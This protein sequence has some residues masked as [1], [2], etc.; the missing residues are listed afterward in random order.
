MSV[1]RLATRSPWWTCAREPAHSPGSRQVHFVP[2]AS[3][4]FVAI[5]QLMTCMT[6]SM[7]QFG[8]PL[9]TAHCA[10]RSC[11]RGITGPW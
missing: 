9:P 4:T 11:R 6:P 10:S 7:V 2:G 8:L 5:P 1:G 3:H